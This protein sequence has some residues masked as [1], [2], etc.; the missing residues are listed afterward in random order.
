VTVKAGSLSTTF[1]LANSPFS[2]C[3][4]NQ[5]GATNMIDAQKMINEALGVAPRPTS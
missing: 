1:S 4:A 5:D 3:D 2:P